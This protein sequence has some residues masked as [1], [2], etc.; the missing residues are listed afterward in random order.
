M[1][2]RGAR[3]LRSPL[4][5]V[6]IAGALLVVVVASLAIGSVDLTLEQVLAAFTGF[7]GSNEHL[8]VRELRLP[9]TVVGIAVGGALG[10]AGALTQAVTRNPLAEPGILGINAG[11]ALAVVLGITFLG[12]SDIGA[13]A[14]FALVGAAVAAAAV[15]LLGSIGRGHGTPI[16]L[17]L[18]G[19][20]LAALLAS[21][22]SAILV[23]NAATLDEFRFWIVGSIAGRSLNA[24]PVVLPLLALGGL[25]ALLG[26]RA[27]NALSLGDD[28]ARS[29]GVRVIGV[30]L[31]ATGA[32]VLLAGAAVALAGPIAFLGLAV[33]HAARLLVGPDW[34]W[35]VPLS[36]VIG[37]SLLLAADVLG[38][39]VVRPSE[40]QVGVVVAI[41]GAPIF[42]ALVRRQ[43]LVEL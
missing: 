1:S 22:T 12:I 31:L 3:E 37:P 17:V 18:G 43:R 35:I 14:I 30:R 26:A 4:A 16:K 15:A 19:A 7:D 28:V 5:L 10:V 40:L 21:I 41:V 29:L 27:L 13:H 11:A 33:P 38:R 32:V 34:R 42:I 39:V 20:V 8:I 23:T 6:A 2:R 24:V 25:A 9:R 36:A